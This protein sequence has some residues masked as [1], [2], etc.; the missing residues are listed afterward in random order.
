[1]R[2]FGVAA[3][4]ASV[5]IGVGT[6]AAC[7]DDGNGGT[8]VDATVTTTTDTAVTSTNVPDTT[9][10]GD[11]IVGVGKSSLTCVQAE[12]VTCTPPTPN[13]AC[14]GPVYA[15]TGN[16]T[17]PFCGLSAGGNSYTCNG[18]ESGP[19]AAQGTFRAIGFDDGGDGD[20]NVDLPPA[21]DFA[22]KLVIDGNTFYNY[23]D[24]DGQITEIRGWIMCAE[25]PE[26]ANGHLFWV[27]TDVI[28]DDFNPPYQAGDVFETDVILSNSDGILIFHYNEVG[29]T[30]GQSDAYCKVGDDV[31]D[32][33]CFDTVPTKPAT[34]N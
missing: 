6:L 22:E 2:R 28:R 12:G 8:D 15:D 23:I 30:T 5:L 16:F 20:A 11:A 17:Y 1:M 4:A 31:N 24:L 29:G 10:N 34:C 33:T 19:P 7:G 3:F 13:A 26:Q 14:D 32:E 18:C 25:K 21:E 9:V 27:I